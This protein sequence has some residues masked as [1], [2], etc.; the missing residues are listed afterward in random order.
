MPDD[1]AVGLLDELKRHATQEKYQLR[2][3]YG[4]GD[5]VIWNRRLSVAS[6]RHTN[7]MTARNF[8]GHG[9]F[10]GRIRP[11]GCGAADAGCTIRSAQACSAAAIV[12]ALWR[13]MST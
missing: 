2:L 5:V 10:V 13:I 7:A 1:E 8:F 12:W 6:Q 4:V 9:D 3:K 11:A